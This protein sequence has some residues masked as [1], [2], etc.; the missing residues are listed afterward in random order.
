M[1]ETRHK[2]EHEHSTTDGWEEE[3]RSLSGLMTVALRLMTTEFHRHMDEAGYA[4]IRQGAG[5]VFEH[6]SPEG[7]TIAS[8]AQRAGVTS[9]AM[10]QTV[11]YLERGGYVKRTPDPSDRRAKLIRITDQGQQML[12]T[13]GRILREMES[14][15]RE[16]LGDARIRDLR[17]SM[18]QIVAIMSHAD[19]E[20]GGED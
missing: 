14:Q 18:Q 20:A 10:V 19:S 11:D 5:N 13:A 1:T 8:M 6:I 9:Q 17:D 15:V 3:Y 4:D 7:S 12:D 2:T 16:V